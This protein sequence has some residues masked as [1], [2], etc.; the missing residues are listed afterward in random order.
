[1]EDK[2]RVL[3]RQEIERQRRA[4]TKAWATPQGF[5]YKFE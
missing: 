4:L 5:E 1:M 2:H 3:P